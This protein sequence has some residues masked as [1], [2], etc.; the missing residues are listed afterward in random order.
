[1]VVEAGGN[2]S[3]EDDIR[4]ARRGATGKGGKT[5]LKFAPD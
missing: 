5:R 4:V 1:M 2:D 3:K